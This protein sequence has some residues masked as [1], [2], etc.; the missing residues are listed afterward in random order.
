M[1]FN[2]SKIVCIGL[3]YRAH[4]GEMNEKLPEH[5]I[6]FLKP[7]TAVIGDGDGIIYPEMTSE[8]HYEAEL[9]IV[10]KDRTKDVPAEMAYDHILGYTCANDITARD[11]QRADGQ[12]TRAKSFDTFCPLGPELVTGID[13]EHLEI[14]LFLNGK[15]MQHSNTEKLIFKPAFLVSFISR[16][17]TILPGDIILTGTPSGVGPMQKGDTVVVE[18]EKVG[19]LTNRV[20]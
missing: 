1:K 12:W 7:P 18:I 13:P 16:V 10:I 11:L 14:K 8:L 6:M 17:M 3:N 4:L 2:P 15:L 19:R 20:T 5:P 9:A